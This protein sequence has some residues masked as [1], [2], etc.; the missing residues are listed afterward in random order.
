M[1]DQDSVFIYFE[2]LLKDA[3][4]KKK[5]CLNL[6]VENELNCSKIIAK[7]K[8]KQPDGNILSEMKGIKRSSIANYT[9]RNDENIFLPPA[10][11]LRSNTEYSSKMK[12]SNENYKGYSSID[13]L[14]NSKKTKVV[15]LKDNDEKDRDDFGDILPLLLLTLLG[16][17]KEN[18]PVQIPVETTNPLQFILPP[19]QQTTRF[20]NA[21]T[22]LF[23][24]SDE[25]GFVYTT[26]Q[27]NDRYQNWIV[28][29]AQANT[30]IIQNEQTRR[31]LYA[32]INA[33]LWTMKFSS[34][35][36]PGCERWILT[37]TTS[38]NIFNVQTNQAIQSD[39]LFIQDL[40]LL[41]DLVPGNI[42]QLFNQ[43]VN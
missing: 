23:L 6:G 39:P 16:N 30:F 28:Q 42:F 29:P 19:L 43:L 21:A 20:Q 37:G 33:G 36:C 1:S 14:K 17:K 7:Y 9:L 27:S 32:D 2:R 31:F 24:E 38:T 34:N 40:L 8:T 5:F 25:A 22:G 12:S 10:N 4:F 18:V 35:V 41:A 13:Y 3:S 26:A 11:S 15:L